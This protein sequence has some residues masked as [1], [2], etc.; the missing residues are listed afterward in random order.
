MKVCVEVYES[1][2]A[3]VSKCVRADVRHDA[4]GCSGVQV[5]VVQISLCAALHANVGEVLNVNLSMET[6]FIC[7][8]PCQLHLAMMS[9]R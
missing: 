8:Q 2:H 7:M 1:V 5:Q 4:C 6:D 3:L 9:H